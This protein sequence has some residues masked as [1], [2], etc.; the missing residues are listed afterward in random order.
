MSIDVIAYMDEM[1]SIAAEY[2]K[3]KDETTISK[4]M[5]I[6]RTRVVKMLNDWRAMITD[7]EAIRQRAKEA[8]AG[9]DKHFNS[10]IN[11]SYE[12]VDDATQLQNLGAK[13]SAIKLIV[14]IEKTRIDMLQKAGLLENKE[15]A[16]QLIEQ[17][18][19]Q[20]V[21]VRILQEVSGQ[22]PTCKHEVTRRLTQLAGPDEA[23]TVVH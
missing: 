5:E 14:D 6:P 2:I 10:L 11:L 23:I 12:V 22:C 8:L 13:T 20:S 16:D 4:E 15:L 17:E 9:A 19:K 21:I 7:N 3:G 18:R 1:N